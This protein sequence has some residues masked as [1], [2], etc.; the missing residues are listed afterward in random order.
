MSINMSHPTSNYTDYLGQKFTF[1]WIKTNKME[2]FLPCTQAYGIC[3]THKGEIIVIN[4]KGMMSIPGGTPEKGESP[5]EALIREL[6]EEADVKIS[7]Y[8]PLGVQT[9]E[10]GGKLESYQYRYVCLVSD[11]L[12]QTPDPDNGIIHPR[13]LVPCDEITSYV[14]WGNTGEAMFKDAIKLFQEKL[15]N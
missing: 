15:V 5:Q 1:T 3:F 9:V 11:V 2:D 14:K 7:I 13:F 10:R 12:P 6:M 8:L 4:N